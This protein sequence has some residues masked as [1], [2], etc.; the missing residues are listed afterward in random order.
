MKHIFSALIALFIFTVSLQAA[1]IKGKI[2]DPNN[3]PLDYVNVVLLRQTNNALAGGG[4]TDVDGLFSIDNITVGTYRLEV[5]FVGYKTYTKPIVIKSPEDKLTVGAIKL[6][7][8]AQALSEVEVVAQGS[9]MRFDIDKKVFNVD[10]N[11]AAAGASASEVLET[12]PSVEVDNDGGVSLRGN[13]S[14]TIWINGKPSG[15]TAD[16]RG[17]I[18]EQL[19]AESIEK[20]EVITNP[21]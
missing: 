21:S 8:D 20:V 13:S 7:E 14:V 16:N 9:Q 17:Q 3:Q 11:I 15:M 12:I 19:P 2:L 6:E 4:I 1:T 18:L 5:S 10:Q